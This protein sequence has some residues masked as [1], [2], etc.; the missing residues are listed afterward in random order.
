VHTWGEPGTVV[1]WGV[2]SSCAGT[3]SPDLYGI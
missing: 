1:G 3:W 2:V